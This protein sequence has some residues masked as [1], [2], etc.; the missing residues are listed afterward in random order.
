MTP[1]ISRSRFREARDRGGDYLVKQL[2]PDGTFGLPER[3]L[4]D[5]C[6]VAVAL[7]VCGASAEANRLCH[8]IRQHG[9]LTNGD[10]GPRPP[11]ANAHWYTYYNAWVIM[12]GHRQGHFDISQKG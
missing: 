2:R 3:G 11:E 12:G 7:Q 6:K 1:S 5:Y 4:A 9:M 10:F 8:W